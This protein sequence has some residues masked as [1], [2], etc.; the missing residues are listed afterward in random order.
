MLRKDFLV[1]QFE[2]FGKF[3]GIVFG[4]K[5]NQKWAELE[6]LINSNSEK[7]TSLKIAAVE[8]IANE[9][10]IENLTSTH[11]LNEAQLQMLADLLYE[12][13]IAYLKQF[14][15]EEANL[16]LGKALLIYSYV[17]ENALDS[18]FSLDRHFKMQT[19]E[20]LLS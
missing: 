8:K 14:K 12:K 10:L 11:K 6:E 20:Q 19:I 9:D 4:L 2:E 16:L 17:K 7:F 1:R 3:L 15:E 13:G 5:N 18:D